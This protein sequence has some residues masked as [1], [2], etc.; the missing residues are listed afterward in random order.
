MLIELNYEIV[1]ICNSELKH[2][3]VAKECLSMIFYVE[4]KKYRLTLAPL[5]VVLYY[6]FDCN[7]CLFII[8]GYLSS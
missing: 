6:E 1:L 5:Q 4:C 8:S 3:N 2:S 7:I